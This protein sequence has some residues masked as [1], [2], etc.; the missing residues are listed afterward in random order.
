[1]KGCAGRGQGRRRRRG[2]TK[3]RGA[4]GAPPGDREAP[5]RA[6]KGR[7]A[8]RGSAAGGGGGP[9]A[10]PWGEGR[11]G[12]KLGEETGGGAARRAEAPAPFSEKSPRIPTRGDRLDVTA[13]RLGARSPGRASPRSR[14]HMSLPAPA[15]FPLGLEPTPHGRPGRLGPL[16]TSHTARRRQPPSSAPARA[17]PPRPQ[18]PRPRDR[19][20]PHGRVGGALR[21]VTAGRSQD[22]GLRERLGSRGCGSPGCDEGGGV[23]TSAQ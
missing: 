12:R 17:R 20:S 23:A 8:R 11:K 18:A 9:R 19:S 16:R 5:R 4:N 3:P 14:R 15:P 2:V 21:H 13:S 1:M 22:G 7:H 10:R 6:P